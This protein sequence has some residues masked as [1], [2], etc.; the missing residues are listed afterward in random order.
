[1]LNFHRAS[2]LENYTS[3]GRAF[4]ALFR[5]SVN[6]TKRRMQDDLGFSLLEKRVFP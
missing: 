6:L 3:I 4:Q 2:F 1:M 5:Q